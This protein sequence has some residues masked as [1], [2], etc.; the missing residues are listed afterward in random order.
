MYAIRSYYGNSQ[1]LSESDCLNSAK[2]VTVDASV[3]APS[4]DGSELLRFYL[5]EA[6]HISNL[7]TLDFSSKDMSGITMTSATLSGSAES[8]VKLSGSVWDNATLSGFSC[9]SY[10]FV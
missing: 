3:L 9:H 6:G 7:G 5:S 8:F 10:N 4:L 1:W 2:N